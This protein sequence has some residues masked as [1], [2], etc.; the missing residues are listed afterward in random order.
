MSEAEKLSDLIGP[1]EMEDALWGMVPDL[2]EATRSGIPDYR[3]L[4]ETLWP[5][6]KLRFQCEQPEQIADV[7]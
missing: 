4:P 3:L 5:L 6:S 7:R 2:P 1:A